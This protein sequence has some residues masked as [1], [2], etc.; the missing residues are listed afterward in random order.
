MFVYFFSNIVILSHNNIAIQWKTI[1]LILSNIDYRLVYHRVI[2]IILK[3]IYLF[4]P[5]V[6]F[7]N[8]LFAYF[9]MT[10]FTIATFMYFRFAELFILVPTLGLKW[11]H[12]TTSIDRFFFFIYISLFCH[13]CI[14]FLSR[15][16]R[17][18]RENIL[19][20]NYIGFG[21]LY[22]ILFLFPTDE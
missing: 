15:I 11:T 20:F 21:R 13:F 10:F 5:T 4:K 19:M 7:F 14:I 3:F 2:P 22:K 16:L 8:W 17:D 1:V 12:V 18:I 6:V 9:F